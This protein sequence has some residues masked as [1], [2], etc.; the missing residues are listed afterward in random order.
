MLDATL[1]EIRAAEAAV[2]PG[3]PM[4]VTLPSAT[5]MDDGLAAAGLIS[6][7]SFVDDHVVHAPSATALLRELHDVGATGSL[8]PGRPNLNRRQLRAFCDH[9]DAHFRDAEGVFATYRVGF[10]LG[11]RCQ[12]AGGIASPGPLMANGMDF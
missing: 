6:T 3:L 7:D 10:F 5:E 9:Y 12:E 1:D 8:N 11:V 4:A 2:V